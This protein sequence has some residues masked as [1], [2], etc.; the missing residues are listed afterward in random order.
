MNTRRHWLDT[1]PLDGSYP[2]LGRP[3]A[4][5]SAAD[6]LWTQAKMRQGIPLT[7]EHAI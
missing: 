5:G 4:A 6:E 3:S 7:V 2:V 1:M